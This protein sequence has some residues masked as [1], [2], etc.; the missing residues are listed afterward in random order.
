M[1]AQAPFLTLHVTPH[2]NLVAAPEEAA[3]PIDPAAAERLGAAFAG[4]AGPGLLQLGASEV[5]TPLPAAIAFWRAFAARYVTAVCHAPEGA[6]RTA[7]EP[8]AAHE[9]TDM[10]AAAPPM[11]GLE[12][13][14]A[15]A[16]AALWTALD[17][18]FRVAFAQSAR[19]LQAFL[20]DRHPAWSVVGRVHFNLA[21]YKLDPETPFAF[22]ASYTTSLSASGAPQHAPLGRALTEY[23]GAANRSQLL[24]L[25][26]PIQRAAEACDWL[27][28]MVDN[29]DVFHPLRWTAADAYR[30]L[31]SV[32]Q[33]EAAG[34]VVRLPASWQTGRPPRP[35]ATATIGT[36]APAGLGTSA[37]LDFHMDVTL[38][39]ETL[40]KKELA[41]LLAATDG[42]HLVRGR[43]IEV[44][45]DALRRMIDEFERIERLSKA[46]GVTFA[47]AMR[48]VAGAVPG[49]DPDER[50]VTREWSEVT[51]G[52]WLRDML[53]GLRS[54]EGLA[55]IDLT[56]AT[57][58]GPRL[59]A[60]LRPYQ[61]VG[62]RWL[63]LLSSLG[64]GACLADDMGLGKTIQVLALVAGRTA[65]AGRTASLATPTSVPRSSSRPPRSSPTGR[66]RWRDSPPHFA[67]SSHTLQRCRARSLPPSI[68]PRSRRTRTWSSRA[69]ARSCACRGWRPRAGISSC[70]TRRRPSR[71][72]P[73]GRPGRRRRSMRARGSR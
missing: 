26:L 9:L 66:P 15:D 36:K 10:A 44:K 21:E 7:V 40:T 18:A 51:A 13:V 67:C 50:G 71:I 42:L 29:G 49:Q 30:F 11:T 59:Q 64:L 63:H 1:A 47:E 2:G 5:T 58:A 28:A 19:P 68:P 48:L 41:S 56:G 65:P 16:L 54:P 46:H 38:D 35:R 52:A 45:R 14:N 20:H 12:Y 27:K 60:T 70:W 73:R 55:R 31:Q 61:E 8:P 22:L 24:A 6:G 17:T 3:P 4:G 34:L 57:E 33:F 69:T 37:L 72:Q 53:A 62:V 25:L 23:A 43:W 32:P 39:G